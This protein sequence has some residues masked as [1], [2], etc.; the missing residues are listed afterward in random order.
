MRKIKQL[1][2]DCQNARADRCCW[3]CDLTPV[4]GWD[5]E[6]VPQRLTNRGL[7]ADATYAIKACPNFVPDEVTTVTR[8]ADAKF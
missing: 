5:A 3:M 8:Y 7:V 1:C 2:W 4:P 6:P